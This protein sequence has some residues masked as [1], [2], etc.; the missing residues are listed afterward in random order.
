MMVW[1]MRNLGFGEGAA[2]RERSAQ[3]QQATFA[4]LRIMDQVAQEV[5]EANVQVGIRRQ[6]VDMAQTAISRAR[7]S[8]Q[9]N[10][11]RIRDG[12]GLPIEVL[13]AIQALEASERAYLRAVADYNRSQLQLQWALGWPISTMP[14]QSAIVASS[15]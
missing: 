9:R 3:I 15:E 10:I 2:R 11:D 4:K 5:A 7:D 13:Q 12:Q 1:E 14:E 6:Q 8:Y